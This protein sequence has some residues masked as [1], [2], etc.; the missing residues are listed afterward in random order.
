[1]SYVQLLAAKKNSGFERL[2][3]TVRASRTIPKQFL[4][5]TVILIFD[6]YQIRRIKVENIS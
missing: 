2:K 6:P 1:M 4:I 3:K 5:I